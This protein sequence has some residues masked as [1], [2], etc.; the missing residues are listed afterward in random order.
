M[1]INALPLTMLDSKPNLHINGAEAIRSAAEKQYC[2]LGLFP[3]QYFQNQKTMG[4]P[5]P[6]ATALRIFQSFHEDPRLWTIRRTLYS[7]D[8]HDPQ[9]EASGFAFFTSQA[10]E[11]IAGEL[12]YSE[13]GP[14]AD[15]VPI[16]PGAHSIPWRG[17]YTWGLS[18]PE[19]DSDEGTWNVRVWAM[20]DG[21]PEG[22]SGDVGDLETLFNFT[23]Q[24]L[25]PSGEQLEWFFSFLNLH[26]D[27]PGFNF[28]ASIPPTRVLVG[29]GYYATVES[30]YWVKCGF[31]IIDDEGHEDNGH[32]V[33]WAT[34][35]GA[36]WPDKMLDIVTHYVRLD[37]TTQE[38]LVF[39]EQPPD[40]RRVVDEPQDEDDT[41]WITGLTEDH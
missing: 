31:L 39:T 6:N 15:I 34:R 41:I 35:F 22:N 4:T 7:T 36:V 27:D 5:N 28:P 8:P 17:R 2:P 20:D 38:G 12:R 14:A 19:F 40:N 9:G 23:D 21:D 25:Q 37:D 24:D 3:V 1:N 13:I 26:D 32:V 11:G 18:Q 16:F 33:N 30:I 29:K 10:T